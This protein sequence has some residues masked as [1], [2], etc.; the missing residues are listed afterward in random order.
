MDELNKGTFST[1]NI[2]SNDKARKSKPGAVN[3]NGG[4]R[5]RKNI[6]VDEDIYSKIIITT[7]MNILDNLYIEDVLETTDDNIIAKKDVISSKNVDT[8]KRY[9]LGENKRRWEMIY[10][11]N[12]DTYTVNSKKITSINLDVASD[13][14]LGSNNNNPILKIDSVDSDT[15]VINGNF[16]V[17]DNS[18]NIG[19]SYSNTDNKINFQT[20]CF[21]INDL[22][23]VHNSSKHILVNGCMMAN[24]VKINGYLQL[25]PQII[26]INKDEQEIDLDS[27]LIFLDIET[28]NKTSIKIPSNSLFDGTIVRISVRKVNKDTECKLFINEDNYVIMDRY[29][30]NIDLYIDKQSIEYIGGNCGIEKIEV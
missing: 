28:N 27:S 26:C 18:Q 23:T 9:N 14:S 22:F 2:L 19:F 7:N 15:C 12:T 30:D 17:L 3:I 20:K 21:D 10:A 8:N 4:M 24:I 1:L 6:I 5:V 13:I 11:N 29:G 16:I 25:N